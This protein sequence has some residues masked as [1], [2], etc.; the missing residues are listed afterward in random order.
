MIV[1]IIILPLSPLHVYRDTCVGRQ[2]EWQREE[3]LPDVM[4]S[5]IRTQDGR[6]IS[7]ESE[8]ADQ[9]NTKTFLQENQLAPKARNEPL[10][11]MSI[12][13]QD[14]SGVKPSTYSRAC[15]PTAVPVP[16]PGP[17]Q[18]DYVNRLVSRPYTAPDEMLVYQPPEELGM[19]S[20]ATQ[21]G[22]TQVYTT[23]GAPADPTRSYPVPLMPDREPTLTNLPRHFTLARPKYSV[24]TPGRKNDYDDWKYGIYNFDYGPKDDDARFDWHAGS[25]LPP[26]ATNIQRILDGFSKTEARR[27]FHER[28]N[29]ISPDLREN[30]VTGKKH[31]FNGLHQMIL[32]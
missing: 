24:L 29:E 17:S 8:Y 13:N 4:T 19:S 28:F 12:E 1:G 14:L 5:D 22:P 6:L 32:R 23:R 10:V 26:P 30:I 18:N 20:P 7:K 16:E 15:C 31:I 11:V 21:R 25:G 9:Y 27:Q 3:L 2:V